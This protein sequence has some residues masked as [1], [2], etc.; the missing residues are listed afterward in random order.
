MLTVSWKAGAGWGV[1]RHEGG[2]QCWLSPLFILVVQGE[3]GGGE[4]GGGWGG[5]GGRRD[6][7]RREVG[8]V[9]GREYGSG[10]TV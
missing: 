5:G 2:D 3:E 1:K 4:N 9:K 7:W 6:E 8:G 10:R